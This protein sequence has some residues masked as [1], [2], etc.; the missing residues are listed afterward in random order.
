MIIVDNISTLA[1]SGKE[2][3]AESWVPLQ[4]WALELRRQGKSVIFVHHAGTNGSQRGTSKREDVLDTVITLKYPLSYKPSMGASF[5][6]HFEKAR[7]MRGEDVAPIRCQLTDSGWHYGP[8]EATSYEK[9]VNLHNE[10]LRQIEIAKEL[11]MSKSQVSKL[12]NKAKKGAQSMSD[13]Q[14]LLERA[15]K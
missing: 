13:F 8:I 4:Q 15:F 14:I 6:L 10:G 7:S 11:R 1:G 9:V 12:V 5:E 2:S 3:E